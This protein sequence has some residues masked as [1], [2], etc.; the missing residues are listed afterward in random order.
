MWAVGTHLLGGRKEILFDLRLIG[1][2][3]CVAEENWAFTISQ[4]MGWN[5]LTYRDGRG[6]NGH[7]GKVAE[8]K[9]N[10]PEVEHPCSG[11]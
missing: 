2:S 10:N 5:N 11:R 3:R 4:A 8:N 9:G 7:K 6:G 1:D